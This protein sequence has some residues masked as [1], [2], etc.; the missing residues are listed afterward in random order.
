MRWSF[1][2]MLTGH[3]LVYHNGVMNLLLTSVGKYDLRYSITQRAT[4][5]LLA[6]LSNALSLLLQ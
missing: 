1:A 6:P 5:L 3:Q 4:Y 2:I